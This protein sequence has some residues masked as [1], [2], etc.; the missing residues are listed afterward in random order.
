MV[1][2]I[3]A[4]G[5]VAGFS[6]GGLVAGG[7]PWGDR[8][9]IRVNAGER[10]LNAEQQEWLQRLAKG[11]SAQPQGGNVRVSGE[12]RMRA[13]DLYAVVRNEERRRAR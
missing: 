12:F 5:A 10:V 11:F 3:K 13:G 7:S 6:N 2:T 9:L 4:A 1:A 8:T